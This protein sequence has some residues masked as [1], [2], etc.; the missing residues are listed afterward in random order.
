MSEPSEVLPTI[1]NVFDVLH[2]DY[3]VVGSVAMRAYVPGR[4]TFDIDILVRMSEVQLAQLYDELGDAW[5]MEWDTAVKCLASH[6]MFNVIHYATAWK[7]DIIPLT[8]SAF[9]QS[10]FGRRRKE[11]LLG[12]SCYVQSPEDLILSKL[13]WGKRSNSARQM[14]DVRALLRA[15]LTLDENYLLTWARELN[16]ADNLNEARR[17]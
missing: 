14:E 1:A 4:S 12:T 5:L 15:G 10:E 13:Q 7:L 3:M 17:V 11:S 6:S 16:V 8:N 9:H 2:V